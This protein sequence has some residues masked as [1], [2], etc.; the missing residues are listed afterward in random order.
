[1]AKGQST[2]IKLYPIAWS[3]GNINIQT[4]Q[5]AVQAAFNV[6]YP[7]RYKL[8]NLYNDVLIDLHLTSLV[9]KR[10]LNLSNK[11]IRFNTGTDKPNILIDELLK[12][13]FPIELLK[14]IAEH[15]FHGF[16]LLWV[17]I[18]MGKK[19]TIK[20]VDRRHVIPEKG[21]YV[22]RTGDIV[23]TNYNDPIFDDWTLKI[24]N[25]EDLGLL[26][27]MIPHV[28]YKRGDISDW[29]TANETYGMPMQKA[30][31]PRG[32]KQIKQELE[33]TLEEAGSKRWVVIP[34]GS[35]L[36]VTAS[37]TN[38][39]NN[40]FESFAEFL[41]REMSKG[42]VGQTMT[43]DAAGGKYKGDVH[44]VTQEELFEADDE[45]AMSIFNTDF[46][47]LLERHGYNPG[48]GFFEY[49][50]EDKLSISDQVDIDTKLAALVPIDRQHFYDK[51]NV[52]PPKDG[53]EPAGPSAPIALP[54]N[55]T[56][57]PNPKNPTKQSLVDKVTSFFA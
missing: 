4:W 35:T 17:D 38:A 12:S 20:L 3:V 9:E 24:G 1:M 15:R 8:H 39:T 19:P 53:E 57:P 47:R 27:K 34:E 49:V 11:K 43:T 26:Y 32:D 30:T 33:Q 52:Q 45:F 29:A 22:Y 51:Y 25:P 21:I 18:A 46:K 5:Q 7:S 41:N 31:Y 48:N 55:P 37:T 42:A 36:D 54:Q 13:Q 10:Q 56:N 6:N 44:L 23:G 2:D 40:G 16:S 14:R 28:I 50:Y